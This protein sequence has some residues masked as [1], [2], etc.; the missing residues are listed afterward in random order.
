MGTAIICPAGPRTDGFRPHFTITYIQREG[1]QSIVSGLVWEYTIQHIPDVGDHRTLSARPLEKWGENSFYITGEIEVFKR[2]LH[3]HL[4]RMVG[5]DA[6]GDYRRA[7]VN[8]RGNWDQP[9]Y[10]EFRLMDRMSL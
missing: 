1:I 6:L 4:K 9:I 3:Q 2:G 5:E 10:K 7:H 8:V